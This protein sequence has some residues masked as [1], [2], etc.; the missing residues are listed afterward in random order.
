M[1]R[2]A[3]IVTS[4]LPVALWHEALGDPTVAD[5]ILVLNVNYICRR[6]A[7]RERA[8]WPGACLT[9]NVTLARMQTRAKGG[10]VRSS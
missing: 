8:P 10:K 2:R 6:I 3:T 5:A 4:Q 9:S 7:S 1:E